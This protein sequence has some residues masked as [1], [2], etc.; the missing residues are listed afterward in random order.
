MSSHLS[1]NIVLENIV[2]SKM[3]GRVTYQGS[4]SSQVAVNFSYSK[5]FNDPSGKGYQRPINKKRCTDFAEYLSQGED[6]L[7]TPILLNAA[8]NWEFQAYN[9]QRPNYGRLICRKKATLM[10]G[11]HRLGGIKEYIEETDSTLSVPFLAFHYLD[12]D[13]EIKLFDV[14][15]TKAKGIGTSLSRYLNRNNDD[16]SWV[17]TNLILKPESPFFS[18]GTLI[19][20]RTKEKH[21]TLQNLYQIVNLLTK[22]SDLAKLPKEKILNITMFYF[23]LIKELLPDEWDDYKTYRLTHITCLNA[24]AIVGNDLIN[25]NY[26]VKSQQ[27]DSV[28]IANKLLNLGEIDWSASGDLKFVK[29]V[30]ATKIL[31]NDIRF[32]L[33]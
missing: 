13:E 25:E 31:A 24:L 14:I 6:S 9:R 21:I 28:K 11:Q 15:N 3:R 22:K 7:Y 23:N 32:C 12:E 4:V 10:D 19:G 17:A 20:K 1:T 18:K 30:A 27:P 33:G 2:Q 8:G 26:L 16:L 5:L 29:G